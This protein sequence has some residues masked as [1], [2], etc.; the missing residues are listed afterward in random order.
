MRN[1]LGTQ[2]RADD[3]AQPKRFRESVCQDFDLL[4]IEKQRGS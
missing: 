3:V 1:S 2:I 4:F